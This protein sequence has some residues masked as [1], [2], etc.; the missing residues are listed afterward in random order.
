[1]FDLFITNHLVST[2]QSGLNLE[3]FVSISSYQLLME[4]MRRL[5]RNMKSEVHFL[6]NQKGFDKVWHKGV[7]F[8]LEENGISGKLLRLIKDFLSDRK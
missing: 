8:K 2:N 4:Y 5:I 6:K 3:T 1:M 7:I